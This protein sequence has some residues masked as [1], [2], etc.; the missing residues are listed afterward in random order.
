MTVVLVHGVPDTPHLWDPMREHLGREDVIAPNLPGFAAP[1]PDGFDAGMNAY[2]EW[3]IGVISHAVNEAGRP[4]DVVGHDWGGLITLRAASLRPELF[5]SWAVGGVS[6]DEE[7]VWHDVAQLWQTPGVGEEL[8]AGAT[9]ELLSEGL[10]DARVPKHHADEVA[11]RGDD[12][13]KDCILKLYRS[14]V[15]IGKD[16]S[17][18]VE[19]LPKRGLVIW[20]EHDPYAE[21]RFG[22]RLASRSGAR[23]HLFEGCGHWWPYERPQET[24]RLLEAHWEAVAA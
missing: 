5:R 15:N 23:F 13:M 12:L 24:A 9:P 22:K 6:I 10:Q 11:A 21:P 4:V 7:Y 3:L 18:E 8:M 14:A 16:W 17:G 20:G 1:I 19:R 2:A